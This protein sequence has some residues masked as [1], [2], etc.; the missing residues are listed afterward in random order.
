[1][2]HRFKNNGYSIVLDVASGS[3]HVVDDLVYDILG[4]YDESTGEADRDKVTE[5]IK[6][7]YGGQYSDEDIDDAF[8]DIEELKA[9]GQLFT[10]DSYKDVVIDFKKRKTVVKALCLHM[11]H[12]CKLACKYCF[13][14]E[15]TYHGQPRK[16]MSEEVGKRALDFL[17][18]NSSAVNRL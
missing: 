11:A 18:E 17:I 15:G 10:E 8:S 7:K 14:E 12:D 2:L 16:L 5:A 4:M 13:A 9:S 6:E 3:V 1:M